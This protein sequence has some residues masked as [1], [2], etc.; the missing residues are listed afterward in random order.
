MKRIIIMSIICMLCFTGCGKMKEK[1]IINQF[2]QNYDKSNGYQ[3]KGQFEV[4]NHDE[5][6]SHDRRYHSSL[7]NKRGND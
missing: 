3:L 1:D 7:F 2:R 5:V 4:T 6:Y